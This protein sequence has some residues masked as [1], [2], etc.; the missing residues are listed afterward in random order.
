MKYYIIYDKL[1]TIHDNLSKA[2]PIYKT[3]IKYPTTKTLWKNKK[4]RRII[5][6]NQSQPNINNKDFKAHLDETIIYDE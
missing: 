4:V 3:L 5:V 1:V 2:H 6:P